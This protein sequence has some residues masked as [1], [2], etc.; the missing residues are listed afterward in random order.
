MRSCQRTFFVEL[1]ADK[2]KS[3]LW[4]Q[5]PGE[6]IEANIAKEF[7]THRQKKEFTTQRLYLWMLQLLMGN[8]QKETGHHLNEHDFR[9]TAYT[10]TAEPM[11]RYYTATEKKTSDDVLAGLAENL[12]PKAK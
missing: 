10:R 3:F 11:L 12:M 9:R 8:Y 6:L 7:P 4:V 1:D 2:G 5:Y